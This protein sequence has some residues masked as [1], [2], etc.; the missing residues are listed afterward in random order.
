MIGAQGETAA[1]R[2]L[3]ASMLEEYVDSDNPGFVHDFFGRMTRKQ[4]G[5]LV[6]KHTDHHLGQF[7]G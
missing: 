4:I 3:W 5:V 6:H 7:A 2:D 1:E